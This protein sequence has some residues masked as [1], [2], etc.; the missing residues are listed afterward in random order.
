MQDNF[1][2]LS[3]AAAG[4]K[5]AEQKAIPILLKASSAFFRNGF[6]LSMERFCGIP[7]SKGKLLL[8]KRNFWIRKAHIHSLGATTWEKSKTLS[9][10][11]DLFETFL[12][13]KWKSLNNV[14]DG[15]S[16]LR[17]SLFE[18]M[19]V[20]ILIRP[21][22]VDLKIPKTARMIHNIVKDS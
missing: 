10:E 14:P 9:N 20:A 15:T 5:I 19:K 8:Q 1:D 18:M 11:I 6:A 7:Q 13:P 16:E 2:I 22:Q 12:W 4:D 21:D 3:R 17:K